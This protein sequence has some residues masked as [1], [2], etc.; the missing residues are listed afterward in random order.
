MFPLREKLPPPLVKIYPTPK[1]MLPAATATTD[2]S[3][4]FP[5][6]KNI[7]NTSTTN[8]QL[9]NMQQSYSK[10]HNKVE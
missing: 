2:V 7:R 8:P 3:M 9:R 4:C 1:F 5:M 6:S 10:L